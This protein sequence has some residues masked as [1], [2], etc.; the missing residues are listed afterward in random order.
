M[1]QRL[2]ISS[3]P[4]SHESPV[5]EVSVLGL[6]L[7][8]VMQAHVQVLAQ[9]EKLRTRESPSTSIERGDW[10]QM[11][12][13]MHQVCSFAVPNTG[14]MGPKRWSMLELTNPRRFS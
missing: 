7:K 1:V 14:G 8:K 2:P 10:H 4:S 13:W 5:L 6:E 9:A 3:G 12:A 11:P